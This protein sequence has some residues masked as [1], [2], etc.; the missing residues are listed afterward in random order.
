[1]PE[2]TRRPFFTKKLLLACV[3]SLVTPFPSSAQQ[4][5]TWNFVV[6]GDSRNCGDVIMPAIAAGAAVQAAQFYWHLGDLRAIYDFDQDILHSKETMARKAALAIADYERIAWDDSIQHQLAAFGE[7]PVFVGIGNHEVYAPKDREQFIIQ[8]A[9]WLD[10]PQLRGQR[11]KDNP[12][13][14]RLKTYFH[15]RKGPVDFVYLDNAT[16]DQFDRE[17]LNWFENVLSRDKEDS[18]VKSIV[19]GMHEALPDSLAAG[20]SMN[21]F[22]VA[23]KSGRMVY[24]DLLSAQQ[25]AHK[26]VYLLASHSHFYVANVFNSEYW[27]THGGVLP[28]WIIGTAGAV[29]YPLPPAVKQ[30]ANAARTDVYGYLLGTVHDNGAIEFSFH[31]I[32]EKD[33]PAGVLNRYSQEFIHECFEKNSLSKN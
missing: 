1:M 23:E 2:P 8:F 18:S 14:H 5:P 25:A 15:W 27:K 22:P 32:T 28:G 10:S 12:N 3:F 24:S 4:S 21:D 11:L 26:N 6:S 20:H 9:D 16:P 7:I 29:R 13:D 30:A 19:V 33:I 31:E 17:Q